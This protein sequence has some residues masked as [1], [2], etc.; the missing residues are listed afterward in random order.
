MNGKERVQAA[1]ERRPVDRVPLG[2]YAV[3][4]DTVQRVL[5]HETYVRNKIAQQVALWE[6]RRSEVAESV[7]KDT[8]ELFRKLDI[9][10]LILPKE[11]PVLPPRD[12]IPDPPRRTSPD[13]WE[14]RNGRV[15][16]AAWDANE[17]ACV[18]D[19]TLGTHA[20]SMDDFAGTLDATPARCIGVRSH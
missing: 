18:Y 11:A 4:Y 15:Y 17:I 10:D 6:G 12:Y 1:I 2:F 14:D 3:D 20:Y 9:A 16:K 5:G 19:P 13:T 8:V 7:K